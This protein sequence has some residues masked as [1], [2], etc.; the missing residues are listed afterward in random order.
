MDMMKKT[1]ATCKHWEGVKSELDEYATRIEKEFGYCRATFFK[2]D[3]GGWDEEYMEWAIKPEF[4][5]ATALVS[6]ASGYA[7]SLSTR[8][9]HYCAMWEAKP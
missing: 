1:C 9:T 2:E 8:P 4:A 5:H 6:D 7:A 3:V